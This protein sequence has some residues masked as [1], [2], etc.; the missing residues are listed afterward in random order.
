MLR[1]LPT[2]GFSYYAKTTHALAVRQ[3][4]MQP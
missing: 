2:A 1:N 3:G 4:R